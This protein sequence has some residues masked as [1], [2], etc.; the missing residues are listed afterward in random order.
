MKWERV[1]KVCKNGKETYTVSAYVNKYLI[2]VETIPLESVLKYGFT[3][4]QLPQIENEVKIYSVK[5][6]KI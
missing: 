2:F 1:L 4:A 3:E 5:S 6:T